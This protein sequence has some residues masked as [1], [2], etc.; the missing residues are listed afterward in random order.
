MNAAHLA[1]SVL[2]TLG[3]V[4]AALCVVGVLVGRDVYQKLHYLGPVAPVSG[5]L[6]AAAVIVKEGLTQ[7]GIKAALVALVLL[8]S[9]A[10]LTHA[11]AR[12]AFI[13]EGAGPAP[14]AAPA[15]KEG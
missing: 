9:G 1:V 13:R 5:V 12:A 15:R 4:V 14:G 7:A 6:I 2:L 8:V 11:T 10:V 3:V